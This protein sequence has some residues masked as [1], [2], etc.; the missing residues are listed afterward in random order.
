MARP[1]RLVVAGGRD[2]NDQAFLDQALQ[3][4]LRDYAPAELL[5]Q[6]SESNPYGSLQV[7]S[8][9]ARGADAAGERWAKA[10][11]VP[12]QRYPAAWDD[13]S[14][15]GAVVRTNRQGR[16]YN[17]NAGFARNAVMA[18]NADAV[19]VMPG[20]RGTDDM[21]RV[22]Q[23]QG[24]PVWDARGGNLEAIQ[25]L[26]AQ[27]AAA[28]TQAPSGA[29]RAFQ[30][31]SNRGE[32]DVLGMRQGGQTMATVKAP[33][34][35]GWLGNPYVADDAGGRYSR[36]EATEKFGELIREKAA[37]PQWREAL[38]GL[39][40]KRIGYYKPDEEFIHLN[41]LSK[42][43]QEVESTAPSPRPAAATPR[44]TQAPLPQPA[45]QLELFS[46][47]Q[48]FAGQAWPWLAAVGGASALAVA[49]AQLQSDRQRAPS[50]PAD[51]R[52]G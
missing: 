12:V 16:P 46:D 45:E 19:L 37:D 15:P 41:A 32:F 47:A 21:V 39:K 28:E 35:P 17:A 25:L 2:F 14:A 13:I 52:Q 31:V 51:D 5:Q 50:Y 30:V 18:Q 8:G 11:G 9:G 3:R 7:V 4:S 33:G 24:L 27:K 20:G 26:A 48:R 43:I 42:W 6:L 10:A 44:A 22:A 36:Q 29:R 34:E 23:K 40:G 1:F 49:V 38:L